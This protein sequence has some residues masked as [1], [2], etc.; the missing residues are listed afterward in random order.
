MIVTHFQNIPVLSDAE[1]IFFL[2]EYFD[3]DTQK[4]KTE[5]TFGAFESMVKRIID[6][7]GGPKAILDRKNRY[8]EFIKEL[9]EE[10]I[11]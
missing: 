5:I 10:E 9:K 4:M 6:L 3:S 7:E 2:K 1:K 11:E 8:A